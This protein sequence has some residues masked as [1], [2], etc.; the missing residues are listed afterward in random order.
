MYRE[1]Q[2]QL[3]QAWRQAAQGGD[4]QAPEVHGVRRNL[5]SKPSPAHMGELVT[6]ETFLKEAMREAS[7]PPKNLHFNKE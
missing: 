4:V 2:K 6:P 5:S 7:K 3:F 1:R